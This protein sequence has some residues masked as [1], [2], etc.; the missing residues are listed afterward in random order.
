MWKL[1]VII[2]LLVLVAIA[3]VHIAYTRHKLFG[4]S[5]ETTIKQTKIVIPDSVDPILIKMKI[6]VEHAYKRGWCDGSNSVIHAFN[7]E[8]NFSWGEKKAMRR[9]KK[10]SI[11]FKHTRVKD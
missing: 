4:N 6:L 2:G 5:T 1:F 9:F 8:E 10:D 11:I 7:E 3:M